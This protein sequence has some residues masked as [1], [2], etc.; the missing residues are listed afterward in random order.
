MPQAIQQ[1]L[2]VQFSSSLALSQMI[3]RKG[4][5]QADARMLRDER[6]NLLDMASDQSSSLKESSKISLQAY[7]VVHKIEFEGYMA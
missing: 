6:E 7:I 4:L 2:L 1:K 3:S 5:E